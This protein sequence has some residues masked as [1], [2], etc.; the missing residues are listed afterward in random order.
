MNP[1]KTIILATMTAILG[2]GAAGSCQA[3]DASS[4]LTMK[5]LHG[6]SFDVGTK[7]AVSYFLSESGQCRLTLIVADA[8]TGD[9]PPTDTPVRFEA[10]ID[11]GKGARF[12]TSEGKALQFGC[13]A[14]TTSMHVTELKQVATYSAPKE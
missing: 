14:S 1:T 5:P 4:P 3:G 6:I 13:A 11:A 12:D 9:E 8:M 2:F 7:R 10:A